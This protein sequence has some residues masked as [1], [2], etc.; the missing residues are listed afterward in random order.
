MVLPSGGR[1]GACAL[2]FRV[3][4]PRLR[5]HS[6]LA[7]VG[8]VE[9]R[10]FAVRP[11]A[12]RRTGAGAAGD[13]GAAPVDPTAASPNGKLGAPALLC[14]PERGVRQGPRAAAPADR[15]PA[16]VRS[17]LVRMAAFA[18]ARRLDLTDSGSGHGAVRRDRPHPPARGPV[19][20][21]APNRTGC[22]TP[23]LAADSRRDRGIGGSGGQPPARCGRFERPLS[24]DEGQSA[25]RRGERARRIARSECE[26]SRRHR[27]P[28]PRRP[29]FTP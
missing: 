17:R 22:G 9:C 13:P 23:A 28:E 7:A 18:I 27:E 4:P 6:R 20:R 14:R 2:L 11:G 1:R 12:T 24:R 5:T 21:P 3:W 16:V 25:F 15:R 29:A 8:A 19:E 10:V 26:S